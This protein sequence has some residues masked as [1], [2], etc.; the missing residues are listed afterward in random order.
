MTY[1]LTDNHSSRLPHEILLLIMGIVS[2]VLCYASGLGVLISYPL[3]GRNDVSP[4]VISFEI[5]WALSFLLILS[6]AVCLI[7]MERGELRKIRR[8]T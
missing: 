7:V 1:K 6:I 5:T 4:L 2:G 8:H 3:G